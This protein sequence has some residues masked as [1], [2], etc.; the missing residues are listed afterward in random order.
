M[1]ENLKKALVLFAK[2]RGGREDLDFRIETHNDEHYLCL[3]VDTAKMDKN[4]TDFDQ[5]YYD[6]ITEKNQMRTWLSFSNSFL[7]KM[8]NEIKRFFDI[9]LNIAFFQKN[10]Q[11]LDKIEKM[12]IEAVKKSSRPEIVVE[13]NADSDDAKVKLVMKGIYKTNKEEFSQYVQEI[14]SLMEIPW[15]IS[16]YSI[17]RTN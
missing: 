12:I 15:D 13:F 10:Y 3:Y 4:T 11:Y 1:T 6:L 5:D 7:K 9:Q 2:K 17:W 14:N 16:V 8:A